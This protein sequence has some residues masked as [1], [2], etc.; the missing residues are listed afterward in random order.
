[1]FF[2]ANFF[3]IP[4]LLKG[5]SKT[6]TK[7]C[8][9]KFLNDSSKKTFSASRWFLGPGVSVSVLPFRWKIDFV[10]KQSERI[11]L[12]SNI[13]QPCGRKKAA[14]DCWFRARSLK[15]FREEEKRNKNL[16]L[17]LILKSIFFCSG[18]FHSGK[19]R[20]PSNAQSGFSVSLLFCCLRFPFHFFQTTFVLRC[21][22]QTRS[23]LLNR[24]V[25]NKAKSGFFENWTSKMNSLV[26]TWCFIQTEIHDN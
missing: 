21:Y 4:K 20:V 19:R 25:S 14:N 11:F 10:K 23:L 5:K 17:F 2:S 15:P 3:E 13:W 8:G 22:E 12:V 6:K 26:W 24:F 16:N 1:M 18:R 9:K 7:I